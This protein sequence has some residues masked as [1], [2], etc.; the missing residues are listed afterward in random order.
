MSEAFVEAGVWD[1][2]LKDLPVASYTTAGDPLKIDFGYRVGGE[3]KMFHAVSLKNSVD[4]AVL[5]AMKFPLLAAG[6]SEKEKLDSRLTAVID[7]H[8]DR[9]RADVEYAFGMMQRN[10]VEIASE[11]EIPQIAEKARQELRA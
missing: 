2:I 4:Q 11:A 8:L 3:L 10:K 9:Q 5:L 7:D 1:L 6:I